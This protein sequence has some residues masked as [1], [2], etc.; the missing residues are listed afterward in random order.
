MKRFQLRLRRPA[1]LAAVLLLI[2]GVALAAG[3]AW[4]LEGDPQRG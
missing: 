3:W 1:I 2:V 4:H